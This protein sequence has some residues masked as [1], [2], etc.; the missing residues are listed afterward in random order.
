MHE[1]LSD[2]NRARTTDIIASK[3]VQW[4]KISQGD[5]SSEEKKKARIFHALTRAY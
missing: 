4:N 2:C 3:A 5:G 1:P